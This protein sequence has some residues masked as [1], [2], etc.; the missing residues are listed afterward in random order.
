MNSL[1]IVP[2]RAPFRGGFLPISGE[3]KEPPWVSVVR[4]LADVPDALDLTGQA[5]GGL[6]M[7][8]RDSGRT[9]V[10]SFG[11]A[12]QRLKAE[13][14]EPE[15]GRRVALNTIP[16]DRLLEVRTEQVFAKWHLSH[17]RA[18]NASAVEEFGVEFD[19]D[20]VSAVEGVSNDSLLGD[21]IRGATSLKLSIDPETLGHVLDRA[22]THFSSDN[23][24]KAW[25]E[26]ETI[27]PL[28]DPSRV[29]ALELL[30]D[31]QLAKGPASRDPVLMT[32]ALRREDL[33]PVDSY[34]VGRMGKNPATVPYLTMSAWTAPLKAEGR[35]PSVASAKGLSI[36]LLDVDKEEIATVSAFEC[37]GYEIDVGGTLHLLSSGTWYEAK[38]EFVKRINGTLQAI[39]KPRVKLSRWNGSESEGE[40][41][42]RCVSENPELLHFDARLLNYGGGRSK[43]EFCDFMSPA[44]RTLFFAKIGGKSAGMSHLFEQVRRTAEM[45]FSADDG[46]R[47]QLIKTFAKHHPKKSMDWLKTRPRAGDWDLCLV[48]L[49]RSKADQ[50]FFAKCGL[51]RLFGDLRERGHSASYLEV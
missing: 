37:L 18:P 27:I 50:P 31:E 24:K 32:P 44:E 36:H 28:E 11:R 3:T 47:K 40:Y 49:G 51:A 12:W 20:L 9:V 10:I 25:P 43:F 35:L 26:V 41:N 23:Y 38:P 42:A 30:L 15:F 21:V 39:G 5:P 16:R 1:S 6:L 4:N 48:S 29:T 13:W 22:I 34:V 14:L 7:I 8:E 17:E 33:P 19:R 46:Y 2:L 45:L